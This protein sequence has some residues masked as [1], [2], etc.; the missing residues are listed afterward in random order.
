ME[1]FGGFAILFFLW[2]FLK[3]VWKSS[4]RSLDRTI[5]EDRLEK[6]NKKR[7]AEV[8]Q[9]Y[10]DCEELLEI[11]SDTDSG[12]QLREDYSQEM[13]DLLK[14]K[15]WLE[16]EKKEIKRRKKIRI[17]Y[18]IVMGCIIGYVIGSLSLSGCQ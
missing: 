4:G 7:M 5:S 18:S 1:V 13:Q 11:F 14:E 2:L 17:I 15:E 3:W 12:S 9:R 8:L 10:Q 16:E 6:E